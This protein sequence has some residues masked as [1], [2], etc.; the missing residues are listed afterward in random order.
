MKEKVL[1]LGLALALVIVCVQWV[2]GKTT[3]SSSASN[4][5]DVYTN[6]MTRS[7]VR[8]YQDKPVEKDK[9]EKFVAAYLSRAAASLMTTKCQGCM[10]QEVGAAIPA[11]SKVSILPSSTGCCLNFRM[12]QRVMM[13]CI[14]ASLA[15]LCAIM[16]AARRRAENIERI[17]CFMG[18]VRRGQMQL[19]S[20]KVVATAVRMVTMRLIIIFQ[21][22]FFDDVLI[23][24]SH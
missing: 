22:S 6:I 19:V 16:G 11:R 2:K 20:P 4:G 21:V 10:S 3:S 17:V 13:F 7:S 1:I 24:K 14:A 18:T 23:N 15:I 12:L 8:S 9:I 5:D